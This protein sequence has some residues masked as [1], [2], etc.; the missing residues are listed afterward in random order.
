MLANARQCSVQWYGMFG[1]NEEEGFTLGPQQDGDEFANAELPP[2]GFAGR[3]Y[4]IVWE[5][6]GRAS[7]VTERKPLEISVNWT[8]DEMVAVHQ[9]LSVT[10][11]QAFVSVSV[12]YRHLG[13]P[14][15]NCTAS[16]G[17]PER[18]AAR[19]YEERDDDGW[20]S[21]IIEC[22]HRAL[23]ALQGPG[24]KL[25]TELATKGMADMLEQM[26]QLEARRE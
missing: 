21:F 16:M 17:V 6:A 8:H 12:R 25:M 1:E 5:I 13:V 9:A 23:E 15:I 7:A 26:K 11:E 10:D 20:P 22:H 19:R 2:P 14:I 4:N 24:K 18:G 3:Y